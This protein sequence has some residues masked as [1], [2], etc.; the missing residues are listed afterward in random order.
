MFY[1]LMRPQWVAL[2]GNKRNGEVS[3]R[4]SRGK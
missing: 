3:R 4:T 2:K 1:F